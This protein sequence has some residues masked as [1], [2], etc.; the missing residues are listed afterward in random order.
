LRHVARRSPAAVEH[1]RNVERRLGVT[2]IRCAP[3]CGKSPDGVRR[4]CGANVQRQRA[5]KPNL[6]RTRTFRRR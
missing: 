1:D 6:R 5:L 2:K 4:A 3:H